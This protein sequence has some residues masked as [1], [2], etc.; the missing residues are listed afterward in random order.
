MKIIEETKELSKWLAK[1]DKSVKKL[2]FVPTMGA[3]HEG[4]M[5]LI[6]RSVEECDY[7]VSSIFINP[8]QFNSKQDFEK[9]PVDLESDRKMLKKAGC[10]LLFMPD[11]H[12]FYEKKPITSFSFGEIEN[13]LEGQF[14]PG[15]FN[16]VGIVLS[17]LFNLVE[18]DFAY[19]GEKDLQQLYLIKQL[20]KDLAFRVQIIGCETKREL[21]GLA[22]S[23]R[24]RRLDD[25]ALNLAPQLYQLL[26]N[27]KKGVLQGRDY[28]DLKKSELISLDSAFDVEY[29]EMVKLPE[30]NIVNQTESGIDYAI[31]VAA[32]LSGIRLI[33]NIQFKF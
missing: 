32:E 4:H 5:S 23:S 27:L 11:T 20:V 8:L 21:S 33:D 16:G 26:N 2:G 31:C 15:H 28:N 24:N 1:A 17:R 18:P 9:Y 22:L 6:E 19:F 25:K 7:T 12:N 3:L 13:I 30:F 14:R 29:L 10:D